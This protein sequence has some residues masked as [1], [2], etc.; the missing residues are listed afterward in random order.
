LAAAAT[1][2]VGARVL[3]GELATEGNLRRFAEE[4]TLLHLATHGIVRSDRPFESL[5]ALQP[6]GTTAADDGRLTA[7]DLYGLELQARL[8]VLSACRSG[9]GRISSDGIL[10]LTRGFFSAGAAAVVATLWDVADEPTYRIMSS[11]YRVLR[12]GVPYD[13]AL[14]EA[15]L[16]LLRA[17]R[18]GSVKVRVG[19]AMVSLPEHPTLWAGFVLLGEP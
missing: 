15:Q 10:G 19:E 2:P 12:S 14:R 6:S 1:F 4:A 8:V 9:S 3:L 16:G 13:R 11:F 7:R 17:L 5:L 18:T